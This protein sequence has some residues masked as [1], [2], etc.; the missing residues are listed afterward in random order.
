MHSDS[1]LDSASRSKSSI[2]DDMIIVEEPSDLHNGSDN[3]PV[4]R[5]NTLN[6]DGIEKFGDDTLTLETCGFDG[7]FDGKFDDDDNELDCLEDDRLNCSDSEF[8]PKHNT[9]LQSTIPLPG[10]GL[11]LWKYPTPF[12]TWL[13]P[14]SPEMAI[15]CLNSLERILHPQRSSGNGHIDPKIPLYLRGRLEA[16]AIFLRLYLKGC[17]WT[18]AAQLAAEAMGKGK[19]LARRLKEWTRRFSL[20]ESDLPSTNYGSWR[21]S[22]LDDEDITQEIFLHLQSL[23]KF[24]SAND[25]VHFLSTD[26]MHQRLNLKKPISLSTAQRWM[27]RHGYRWR[28]ELKGQYKDGHE[29]E[30]VVRYRQEIFLPQIQGFLP[31]LRQ[32]DGMIEVTPIEMRASAKV[33]FWSQDECT[34]VA[35]D[36]RRVRWVHNSEF[37]KPHAK[38]EGASLMVSDF[39]SADY[40]WLCSPNT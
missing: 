32:W 29:D 20:D 14:L 13:S 33:V 39:V 7:K 24:I 8:Q 1:V 19:W 9:H 10:L 21:Q 36:E 30:D 28:T 27:H 35:N 4:C 37:A 3:R 31:Q 22:V 34:F 16:M 11:D 40:G 18:E 12:R 2:Q 25:V 17:G 15:K 23:G 5:N 38:G 6:N 26:E